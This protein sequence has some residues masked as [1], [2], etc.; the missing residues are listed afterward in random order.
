MTLPLTYR[1]VVF[2]GGGNRC[3]W[4]AGFLDVIAPEIG[5]APKEIAGVSAGATMACM[6]FPGASKKD[7][8]I[9]ERLQGPIQ[10]I[11]TWVI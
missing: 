11:S 9:F 6:I 5:L 8:R 1:S 3:L 2:A 7:L 4:Q 10:R